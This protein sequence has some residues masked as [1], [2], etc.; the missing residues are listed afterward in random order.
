MLEMCRSLEE[1]NVSLSKT[2]EDLKQQLAEAKR[3]ASASQLI[4]HYRLAILRYTGYHFHDFTLHLSFSHHRSKTY[5][6]NLL[7]QIQ[8]EQVT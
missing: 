1:E 2:I 3:E 7:E 4:P 8:R 5:A 6:S